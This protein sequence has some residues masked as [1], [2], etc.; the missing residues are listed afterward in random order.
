MCVLIAFVHTKEKQSALPFPPGDALKC[1]R[2]TLSHLYIDADAK[3]R[4]RRK[5]RWFFAAS[6]SCSLNL[7][8]KKR[9]CGTKRKG[10]SPLSS[11]KTF[12]VSLC[13]I[14]MP[15]KLN[16]SPLFSRWLQTKSEQAKAD[17]PFYQLSYLIKYLLC[18][19]ITLSRCCLLE[20]KG[21]AFSYF[22]QGHR[23]KIL[24]T[25]YG[26]NEVNRK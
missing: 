14:C 20:R 3:K 24:Y 25:V 18:I 10:E 12:S 6:S 22:P 23:R 1:V 8:M 13:D 9:R 21:N 16:S 17:T 11:I 19:D 4:E 5:K 2:L 15:V 7:T 26:K